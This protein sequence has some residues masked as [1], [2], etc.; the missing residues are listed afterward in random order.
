MGEPGPAES[1]RKVVERHDVPFL[2]DRVRKGIVREK[3]RHDL[4]KPELFT[5]S[6]P[7]VNNCNKSDGIIPIHVGHKNM[8][9]HLS[10]AGFILLSVIIGFLV[11]RWMFPVVIK[12]LIPDGTTLYATSV[13]ENFRAFLSFA[14]GVCASFALV[15]GFAFYYRQVSILTRLLI[16]GISMIVGGWL[17]IG[18]LRGRMD[19][20]AARA[21]E[22]GISP[23]YSIGQT[24][25]YLV[26]VAALVGSI[27]GLVAIHLL[28]VRTGQ[29]GEVVNSE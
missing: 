23:Y 22:F 10:G 3:W 21:E 1:K 29:P 5:A 13:T 19:G 2:P 20:I 8:K 15:T 17:T 24:S 12:T 7:T 25:T 4:I 26:P 16:P 14:A 27:V 6:A 28:T 9:K 18:Y 11:S